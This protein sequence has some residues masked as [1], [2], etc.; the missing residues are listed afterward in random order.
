MP[1]DVINASLAYGLGSSGT[2]ASSDG[3]VN[4]TFHRR[5][6]ALFGATPFIICLVWNMLDPPTNHSI[7]NNVKI[8]H[9]LWT[10]SFL[11][12]YETEHVL[13]L[14]TVGKPD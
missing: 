8:I 12:T 7:P 11:K 10:F 1:E 2:N 5:F 13:R 3:K 6:M 9:L 4:P 14:I